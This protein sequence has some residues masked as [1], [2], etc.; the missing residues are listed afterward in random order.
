MNYINNI[1][2][3]GKSVLEI[4]CGHGLV[5]ILALLKGA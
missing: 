3:T 4:G 5:G 2:F 1:D